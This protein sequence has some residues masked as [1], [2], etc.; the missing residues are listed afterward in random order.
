MKDWLI[1]CSD[2]PVVLAEFDTKEEANNSYES[3]PLK[4][5]IDV[6]VL[7]REEFESL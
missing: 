6:V 1:V 5:R 2:C 4:E 7:S 3:L